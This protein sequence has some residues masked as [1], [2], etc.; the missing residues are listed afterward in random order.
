MN[1]KYDEEKKNLS[2]NKKE[3]ITKEV[4]SKKYFGKIVYSNFQPKV[5][6]EKLKA[7]REQK[8]KELNGIGRYDDIKNL[9]KK[10]K[11]I[12]QKI[13]TSQ[14]KN[15]KINNKFNIEDNIKKKITLLK[16]K[17]YK[18]EIKKIND[19]HQYTPRINNN[20][21]K[22][23][24]INIKIKTEILNDKVKEKKMLLKYEKNSGNLIKIEQLNSELSDLYF[25][26]I[27][28]KLKILEK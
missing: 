13:Y 19:K 26:S 14:P 5:I 1:I 3:Q 15:F 25:N 10:L 7:E 23:N 16:S 11:S 18:S 27:Q 6:N 4:N 9:D 24:E 28:A 21:N 22:N 17:E 8:I 20:N 2:I 12:S